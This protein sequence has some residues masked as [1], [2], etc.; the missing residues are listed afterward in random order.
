VIAEFKRRSPSAG[1]L[2]HAPE[3]GTLIASYERGGAAAISIL[4]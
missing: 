2:A 3:L 4:T 1:A